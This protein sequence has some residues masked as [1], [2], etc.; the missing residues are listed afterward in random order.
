[1]QSDK[2]FLTAC[3]LSDVLYTPKGS[4]GR[5][6]RVSV[7]VHFRK[8]EFDRLFGRVLKQKFGAPGNGQCHATLEELH[9]VFDR[10]KAVVLV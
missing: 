1:M 8:D 9:H 6:R 3:S 2:L 5:Q 4:V 7:K 10:S